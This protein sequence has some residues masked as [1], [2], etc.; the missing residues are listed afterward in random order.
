VA[1][2]ARP[3]ETLEGP[4]AATEEVAEFREGTTEA[5]KNDLST[6][7]RGNLLRSELTLPVFHPDGILVMIRANFYHAREP[8]Q[9]PPHILR[10]EGAEEA[11]DPPL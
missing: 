6:D 2:E 4:F 5:G 1:R 11:G 3:D 7:R 9:G 8:L 10:S